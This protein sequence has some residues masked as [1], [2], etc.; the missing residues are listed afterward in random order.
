[1]FPQFEKT[2]GNTV[3]VT[4]AGTVDIKK[5]IAAGEVFDLV[6]VASPE[7]D[8]FLNDGKFVK[9]SKVDLGSV[10]NKGFQPGLRCDSRL[11][12]R[13]GRDEETALL[14]ERCGMEADRAADAAWPTRSSSR[15]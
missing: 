1:L 15:R 4:W 6:I 7:V 9:G 14:A 10:P 3:A 5:K 13:G 12:N 11:P 2:S 8:A